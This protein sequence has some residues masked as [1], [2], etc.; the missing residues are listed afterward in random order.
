MP[1]SNDLSRSS[2]KG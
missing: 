2:A 1:Q